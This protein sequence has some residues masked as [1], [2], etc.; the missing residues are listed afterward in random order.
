MLNLLLNSTFFGQ[1]L[2]SSLSVSRKRNIGRLSCL[3]DSFCLSKGKSFPAKLILLKLKTLQHLYLN[4]T[5]ELRT[6]YSYALA[7][8]VIF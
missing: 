4:S 7:I 3:I 8:S 6:S 2:C 5:K 1:T